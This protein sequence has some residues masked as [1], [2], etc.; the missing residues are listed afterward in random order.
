M[1]TWINTLEHYIADS[2]P[3]H[4]PFVTRSGLS[5]KVDQEGRFR[6]YPGNTVV[7][8]LDERQ[9]KFLGELQKELYDRA[10]FALAQPLESSTFH[11]TAHDLSNINTVGGS[12]QE[13]MSQTEK[14]ALGVVGK[15]RAYPPLCMD[16]TWLFNMVNTSVVLGLKPADESTASQLAALY[17]ELEEIV[18]LGYPLTPHI[19]MAYYK[20]GILEGQ[21]LETL[22]SALHPVS[23]RIVIPMENLTVQNFKHMNSYETVGIL[24]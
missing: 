9:Q 21:N 3:H 6:E 10:G 17:Q 13:A 20:P 23:F 15:Y 2:L 5:E 19:T 24:E 22:R 1:D 12:L 14:Q 8:L 7:F 18:P 16:T 11:M 4:E